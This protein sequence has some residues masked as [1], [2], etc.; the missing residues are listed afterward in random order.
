MYSW[1]LLKSY[2]TLSRTRQSS[3]LPC[4]CFC[5]RGHIHHKPFSNINAKLD[6]FARE[7]HSH[8]TGNFTVYST[9]ALLFSNS[10]S[11]KNFQKNM[12][13]RGDDHGS[14][15]SFRWTFTP[16]SHPCSEHFRPED[17]ESQFSAILGTSFVGRR[18]LKN[19]A[20]FLIRTSERHRETGLVN[21]VY[22]PTGF[23]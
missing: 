18:S 9:R 14:S 21:F 15:L 7:K 1:E 20:F 5:V 3:F 23:L 10:V 16:T 11:C 6:T 2:F 13:Q 17:F 19:D 12:K 4:G 22:Y 8:N